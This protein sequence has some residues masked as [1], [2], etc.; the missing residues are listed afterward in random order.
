M[1]LA[2]PEAEWQVIERDIGL[3][4]R[5]GGRYHCQHLSSSVS[6]S[7]VEAA[8]ADGLPITAEVTAHHLSHTY[9]D[10]EE[11]GTNLKMYPPVRTA[12]DRASLRRAILDGTIDA[13]ATDHA[14]HTQEEKAV[15]FAEAP[16]GVI[17]LETAASVVWDV[18]GDPDILFRVLS[19]N[20]S[21][22]MSLNSHGR[23]IE[24][25]GPANLTVFDP[26]CSWEVSGFESKSANSPYLG[27]TFG[28]R[29]VATIF[30]GRLSHLGRAAA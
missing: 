12:A 13:V 27:S 9:E 15:P 22:L 30:T 1:D 3:V 24:I 26:D 7:L 18:T 25:G 4:A 20:P 23:P 29:V 14:P 8:K 17:G 2:P 21:R 11:L 10:L 16:R 6:V 28:G 19:I 5:N